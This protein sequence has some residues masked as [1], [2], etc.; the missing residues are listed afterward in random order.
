MASQTQ[1][2]AG[3][4]WHWQSQGS[5]G[6]SCMGACGASW[7][8][9]WSECC[10]HLYWGQPFMELGI[11]SAEFSAPCAGHLPLCRHFLAL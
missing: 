2:V 10:R 9:I 11:S 7:W 4:W 6:T 1:W 8:L 3:V 5:T